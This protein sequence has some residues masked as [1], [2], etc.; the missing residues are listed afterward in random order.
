MDVPAEAGGDPL[1][2]V[3]KTI[4]DPYVG[5]V[6]LFRVL[7]GT[8]RPDDHLVNSRTGTDERLHGLL[9][10]RGKE[11]ETG[12]SW[13]P[14]TSAPWPS[15]RAPPPATP[16]PPRASRSPSQ[17]SSPSPP[18]RWRWCPA[19]RPTRTGW[20]RRCTGWSTRTRPARR[21]HRRDAPDA[22]ARHQRD[23]PADHAGEADPQVRG[24]R[25][26][27]ARP[28]PLPRDDH[29]QRQGRRGPA[30][31]QT[32]GHGQFG[33]CVI[34]LEPMPRGGG[35]EFANQIVGGA[36]SRGYIPQCRRASRRRWAPAA[37]T[38]TRWSTS[39]HPDRRQGAL[40][41]QLGDGVQGGRPAGVP[42]GDGPGR[43]WCSSRSAGWRS[44][45]PWT[46]RAT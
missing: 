12:R 26:H 32:G 22:A 39:G 17:S 46:S 21:A 6:S 30:Q 36:I 8:L 37:P 9:T 13:W 38:A 41:R 45:S 14:A 2:F 34:D 16:W 4:A 44:R 29:R 43:R 10:V 27:R 42:G 7:S 18:W 15:W 28:G 19:P 1:A 35:F 11:Q 40:G 31:E 33:V 23:P 24:Q 20:P 5:Q 3:F 25:R